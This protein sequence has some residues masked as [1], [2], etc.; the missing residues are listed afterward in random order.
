MRL[1]DSV[2]PIASAHLASF[3]IDATIIHQIASGGLIEFEGDEASGR[4]YVNEYGALSN[5][6]GLLMLGIYFDRYSGK[7]GGWL[8]QSR[9]IHPLYMGPPRHEWRLEPLSH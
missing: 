4:F 3:G 8:F 9:R 1:R 2:R 5:G 7:S 6:S